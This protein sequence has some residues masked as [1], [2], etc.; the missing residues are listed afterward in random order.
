MSNTG[1]GLLAPPTQACPPRPAS[2]APTSP[3]GQS[4]SHGFR[5]C[6][7]PQLAPSSRLGCSLHFA[8]IGRN[9]LSLPPCDVAPTAFSCWAVTSRSR[10][11]FLDPAD[12]SQPLSFNAISGTTRPRGHCLLCAL[13]ESS[14]PRALRFPPDL[15]PLAVPLTPNAESPLPGVQAVLPAEGVLDGEP[16]VVEFQ[17]RET[18]FIQAH[19]LP[20]AKGTRLGTVPWV[21][22]RR[23]GGQ[24]ESLWSLMPS[25]RPVASLLPPGSLVRAETKPQDGRL[26]AG[27]PGCPPIRA[28]ASLGER[29][30]QPRN[31]VTRGDRPTGIP[32]RQQ[33]LVPAHQSLSSWHTSC[34]GPG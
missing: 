25:L 2:A 32:S 11:C 7:G 24:G 30:P 20:M 31:L 14:T 18:A 10:M 28:G 19:H 8:V 3:L 1:E 27:A 13:P 17:G 6:P 22:G 9:P 34:S 15:H 21:G 5:A 33:G 16:P 26:C 29:E 4:G 12:H 23:W